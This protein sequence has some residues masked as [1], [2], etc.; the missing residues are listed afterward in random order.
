MGYSNLC[1]VRGS[2]TSEA[3]LRA[4]S[5]IRLLIVG[6]VCVA[7]GWYGLRAL[8][9]V[10]GCINHDEAIRR[11][12][13]ADTLTHA[14][15]SALLCAIGGLCLSLTKFRTNNFILGVTI[16]LL[17]GYEATLHVVK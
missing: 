14:A 13:D 6:S 16:A 5:F 12:C 9:L 15:I 4:R 17:I 2:M 8:V 10:V 7:S 3:R 11:L 1:A